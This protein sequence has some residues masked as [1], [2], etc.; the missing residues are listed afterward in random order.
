MGSAFTRLIMKFR[1]VI[2]RTDTLTTDKANILSTPE[3]WDFSTFP[4]IDLEVTIDAGALQTITIDSS[5]FDDPAAATAAEVID[6]INAAIV[7]GFAIEDADHQIVLAT[8]TLGNPGSILAGGAAGALLGFDTEEVSGGA[9]DDVWGAPTPTADGTQTGAD[10]RRELAPITQLCQLDRQEWGK[11][12]LTAGGE[13]DVSDIVIELRKDHLEAAGLMGSN[14]LPLIHIG[15][16]ID[17]ILQRDGTVAMDFPH[18]PGMW[19]NEVE[20]LGYGLTY[21]GTAEINLFALHCKKDRE[22][23]TE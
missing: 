9:Y 23:E 21:F 6:Q 14:G 3:T 1:V 19:V 2:Y 20:P 13:S 17:R 7:G 4:T 8:D 16:R 15:D 18:P 22:I 11:R 5:L 12:T 10:S